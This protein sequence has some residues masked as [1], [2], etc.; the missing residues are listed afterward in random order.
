MSCGLQD[1]IEEVLIGLGAPYSVAIDE[2]QEYIFFTDPGNDVAVAVL[3]LL[4]T[5]CSG[6][7]PPS[8]GRLELVGMCC[9]GCCVGCH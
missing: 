5:L 7:F 8:I 9:F 3:L 6:S 2:K 4:L 1:E